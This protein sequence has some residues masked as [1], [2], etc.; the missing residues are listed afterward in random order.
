MI[1]EKNIQVKIMNTFIRI[2]PII[3]VLDINP[4]KLRAS[5]SSITLLFIEIVT[6]RLMA[7]PHSC[8]LVANI[9]KK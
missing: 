6:C 8:H 5:K 4:T 3:L 2:K 7:V 1:L 9:S